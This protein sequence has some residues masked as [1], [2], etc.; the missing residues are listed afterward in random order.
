[1]VETFNIFFHELFKESRFSH[2]PDLTPTALFFIPQDTEVHLSALE[3]E[4]QCFGNLLNARIRRSSAPYKIEIVSPISL[5]EVFD[6]EIFGEFLRPLC[7]LILWFSPWIP[8]FVRI[9]HGFDE[10]L[11]DMAFLHEGTPHPDHQIHGLESPGTSEGTGFT[12]GTVPELQSLAEVFKVSSQDPFDHQSADVQ[13]RLQGD[14]AS[15]RALSALITPVEVKLLSH[16]L[17]GCFHLF[18]SSVIRKSIV[19]YFIYKIKII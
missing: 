10:R 3:I 4:G 6:L 19:N 16:C 14:R 17:F 5:R 2:P 7:S 15:P 13:P 1:M 11:G 12:G 8:M 9:L 18:K